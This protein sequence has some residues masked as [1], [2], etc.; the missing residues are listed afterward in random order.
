[1]E[2]ILHSS[3]SKYRYSADL[4]GRDGHTEWFD[5]SGWEYAVGVCEALC[6]AMH[7]TKIDSWGKATKT[8]MTNDDL[9]SLSVDVAT[10]SESLYRLV[11]NKRVFLGLKQ[12]DV[13]EKAKVGV[14]SYRRFIRGDGIGFDAFISI[15]DAVGL[16]KE[17]NDMI[18]DKLIRFNDELFGNRRVRER[19]QTE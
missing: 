13:A 18:N 6:P 9:S 12:T 5:S 15:L 7:L 2:S 19:I 4:C 17:F 16:S 1:M 8:V 3:L 10:L 11:E 14:A